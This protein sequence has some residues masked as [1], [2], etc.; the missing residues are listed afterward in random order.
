MRTLSSESKGRVGGF[1][2]VIQSLLLGRDPSSLAET[3][4]EGGG[5]RG[6]EHLSLK[7]DSKNKDREE[8]RVASRF[9]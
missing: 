5:H 1:W 3:A 7:K 6:R 8:C 9:E 4:E 2:P